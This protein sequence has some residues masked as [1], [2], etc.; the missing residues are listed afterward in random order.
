[1]DSFDKIEQVDGAPG[2][3]SG[4]DRYQAIFPPTTPRI[5]SRY[6]FR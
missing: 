4:G 3:Q 2:V 5:L 6:T 1:M